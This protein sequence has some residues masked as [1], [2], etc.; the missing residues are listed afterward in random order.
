LKD[1]SLS[2]LGKI[3][4]SS[5]LHCHPPATRVV[6]G[7]SDLGLL[8]ILIIIILI[9]I[10]NNQ[11]SNHPICNHPI[12]QPSNHPIQSSHHPTTIIIN[13]IIII[14]N[15]IIIANTNVNIIHQSWNNQQHRHPY[16]GHG[17]T[18]S[19]DLKLTDYPLAT[20][21]TKKGRK[22]ELVLSNR[23]VKSHNDTDTGTS[24]KKTKHHDSP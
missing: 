17:S 15:N 19:T 3:A 8:I 10:I 7:V 18:K 4:K 16:N 5:F 24:E 12:V 9:I 23:Q 2:L 21:I 6:E 11:S 14:I 13:N 20:T 1:C 22:G